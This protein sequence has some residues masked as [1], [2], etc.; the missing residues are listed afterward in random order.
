MMNC[1]YVECMWNKNG[2][3]CVN[4]EVNEY[5][6]DFKGNCK[7]IKGIMY[8][9]Q[10]ESVSKNFNFLRVPFAECHL[11]ND[12]RG[13]ISYENSTYLRSVNYN[14]KTDIYYLDFVRKNEVNEYT[15]DG[16]EI[17]VS[18]YDNY[19]GGYILDLRENNKTAR[20]YYTRR[21]VEAINNN[22]VLKCNTIVTYVPSHKA[23]EANEHLEKLLKNLCEAIPNVELVECLERHDDIIKLTDDSKDRHEEIHLKSVKLSFEEEF[24]KDKN[25]LLIDDMTLTGNSLNACKS[26]LQEAGANVTCLALGQTEMDDEVF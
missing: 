2:H 22:E 25:I 8:N 17:P 1:I 10:N 23:N 26:L 7:C 14:D 4:S 3:E 21:L 24:Y 11:G 6:E 13:L 15:D 5:R 18:N 9:K 12:Y 16:E 20:N 19:T